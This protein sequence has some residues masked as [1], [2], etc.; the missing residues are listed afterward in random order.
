M[1]LVCCDRQFRLRTKVPRCRHVHE[2]DEQR[3]ADRDDHQRADRL[4]DEAALR[5]DRLELKDAARGNVGNVT[6][7]ARIGN[8]RNLLNESDEM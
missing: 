2:Q 6:W 1:H 4:P 7:A 8:R 3:G 5:G